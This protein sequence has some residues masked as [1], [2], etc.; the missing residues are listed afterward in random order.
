[1]STET[2]ITTIQ[3]KNRE[4]S[5]L[6]Q[7]IIEIQNNAGRMIGETFTKGIPFRLDYDLGK[8][9]N[10][11]VASV[12]EQ[13]KLL[14][15][16]AQKKGLTVNMQTGQISFPGEEKLNELEKISEGYLTTEE[17]KK[18]LE[19][20]QAKV[21]YL[22]DQDKHMDELQKIEI[23]QIAISEFEG[24]VFKDCGNKNIFFKYIVKSE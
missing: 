5:P 21:T 7:S 19:M 15:E 2:T 14:I 1:M 22:E 6:V 20:K 18:I 10:K 9:V 4:L 24:M 3:L 16:I 13:T 8:T 11:I 17:G 23:K 12:T